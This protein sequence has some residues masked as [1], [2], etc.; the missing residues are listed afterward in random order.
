M[1]VARAVGAEAPVR[2]YF[3]ESWSALRVMVK[4]LFGFKLEAG[5][6]GSV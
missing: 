3:V 5:D 1:D 4:D 6:E 2:R